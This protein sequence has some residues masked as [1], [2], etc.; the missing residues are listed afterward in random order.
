MLDKVTLSVES[1]QRW[2][3]V[4]PNGVGKSTLLRTLA[5]LIAPDAGRVSASPLSATIG[6][7]SQEPERRADENVRAY[8]TRRTGVTQA[9]EE[10]D[11]ST[12]A[13]AT[14]EDGA[15]D[16]YSHALDKWLALGGAELPNGQLEALRR[17]LPDVAIEA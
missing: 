1:G 11:A 17:A 13:L 6:Y 3:V 2:G 9:A 10:L 5:G 16:A 14:G 15:D 12:A 4:G 7:L 8:L